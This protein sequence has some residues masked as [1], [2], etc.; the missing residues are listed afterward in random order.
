M[1]RFICLLLL[2]PILSFNTFAG[3]L[4]RCP[5]LEKNEKIDGWEIQGRMS[6]A[7]F[8]SVLI[9]QTRVLGDNMVICKYEDELN[10][11]QAGN[12]QH[13]SRRGYWEYINIGGLTFNQCIATLEECTFFKA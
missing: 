3:S 5:D 1:K 13:G 6:T 7:A 8:K 11:L 2:S 9:R 4:I 12:F 10:L